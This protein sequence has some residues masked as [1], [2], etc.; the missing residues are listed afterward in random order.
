MTVKKKIQLSIKKIKIKIGYLIG[1]YLKLTWIYLYI[2]KPSIY[3]YIYK[4]IL[5]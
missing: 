3:I 1:Y 5:F 2:D 4:T